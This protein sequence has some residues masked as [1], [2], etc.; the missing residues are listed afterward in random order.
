MAVDQTANFVRINVAG[1]HT[2]TD[3]T[4]QLET[5]EASELPDPANGEYNLTW[6]DDT[7]ADHPSDDD[8]VEIVRVTGVDTA[9]DTIT[10][11]RGR[12]DTTAVAHD[13]SQAQYR[14]VL[15]ATSGLFD[16]F[17]DVTN[18]DGSAGSSGQFLKTDGSN[19]TFEKPDLT[20][21]QEQ[22]L[23]QAVDIAELNYAQGLNADN[24]EN[25]FVD[26]FVDTSKISSSSGTN[27]ITGTNGRVELDF[28]Q[29]G[30]ALSTTYSPYQ[31][32]Q[33]N[34]HGM[35]INPNLYLDAIEL[36]IDSNVES[37]SQLSIYG[38][39]VDKTVD[40]SSKSPGDAVKVFVNLSSGTDYAVTIDATYRAQSSSPY[41]DSSTGLDV[42]GGTRSRTNTSPENYAY[43]VHTFKGFSGHVSN[44]TL[45]SIVIDKG[46]TPSS[47]QID[48]DIVTD[49]DTT[50][51][52]EAYDGNG[53][54]IT[55]TESELDDEKTVS[56]SDSSF[57]ID[58]RPS[59]SDSS[60]SPTVNDY[61]L[62]VN[63]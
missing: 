14:M 36:T 17:K 10:V 23:D 50:V 13:N 26:P 42:L 21:L 15:S 11:Q 41:S 46:Y 12:E 61:G 25:V 27:V 22:L 40:I 6:W 60:K 9:N 37:F 34:F 62:K 1:T 57:K 28:E 49:A 51:E 16:Q 52:I 3:T 35:V 38:A 24:R 63:K 56:F 2:S 32:S 5:G 18:L 7:F 39:D 44:G 20:D 31:Y 53:N 33:D 54:S 4:I 30:T 47:L 45:T 48:A 19:L 59:T 8:N 29:K 43:S 58:V 55:W